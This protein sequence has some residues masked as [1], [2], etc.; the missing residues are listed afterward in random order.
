MDLAPTVLAGRVV[1]L[2]PLAENHAADL[3]DAA[4]HDEVWTYL[5]EPTPRTA[6]DVLAM[7]RQANEE[8]ASGTRMPFAIVD[9]ATGHAI[10]SVSYIDIRHHDRAVE[11]GWAWLAPARWGTGAYREAITLLARYAFETLG[12]IRV[13]YKTDSRNLRSQKSILSIGGTQEGIFRNHRILSNGYVRDSVYYSIID[14][15][16]RALSVRPSAAEQSDSE[17]PR[18]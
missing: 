16:W 8:F 10:G 14:E 12:V 2:E 1:R 17:T 7:I 4:A 15:D 9:A 18:L 3:F 11:I 13:A 5:D 6:D